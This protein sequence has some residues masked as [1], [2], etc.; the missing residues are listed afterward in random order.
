MIHQID[1]YSSKLRHNG[2]NSNGQY[3]IDQFK[4][5]P[6]HITLNSQLEHLPH[7]KLN[8]IIFLLIFARNFKIIFI[9]CQLFGI[10]STKQQNDPIHQTRDYLLRQLTIIH[11][12]NDT[13]IHTCI[14]VLQV[15]G[16]EVFAFKTQKSRNVL[17][18][19]RT[20]FFNH[21]ACIN[22]F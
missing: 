20:H 17:F 9:F 1:F 3:Q 11:S 5:C 13:G 7:S 6:K 18:C 21:L 12:K 22:Y 19:N 16:C 8:F 4:R 10:I 2:L 14:Q 15:H